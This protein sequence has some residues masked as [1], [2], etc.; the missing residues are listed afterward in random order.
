MRIKRNLLFIKAWIVILVLFST[1]IHAKNEVLDYQRIFLP[2][3]T[4]DGHLL[5]AIRVFKM[6]GTPS[7]LAVNPHTLETKVIPIHDLSPRKLLKKDKPGYFS[8]WQIAKT[9]Y[10]QL[11]NQNTAPP[12]LNQNQ[13]I[14]HANAVSQGN[15]LSIDLCPSSKPFELAFFEQL[16]HLSDTKQEPIPIVIAISGMW[17][18]K[19]NEE[20]Q[21]LV[22]KEKQGKL[23]I[24]W[25]NHSFSHPY[26]SDLP[27]S[28]N[29]LL[30]PR[31][32][33]KLEILLTEQYLLEA[34]ELPS[35]FFRFPG[36]ISNKS[37]INDLNRYGLIPLGADAWLA[38]NQVVKPGSI[39]LVHGNS[40]EHKGILKVLPLLSKL[41]WLDIKVG[42]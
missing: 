13:G 19:H 18:I 37:L 27:D 9:H 25:V 35:V 41:M 42:I 12:Y 14:T 29:F 23:K 31:I 15:I 33:R 3:H 6:N 4:N 26:L 16:V 30:M 5:L 17:L 36:L 38:K 40:N 8:Q 10:Y 21:W 7:F 34:G 24:T 22:D 1:P 39:I 28:N 20:F 11:L 32:N 2:L